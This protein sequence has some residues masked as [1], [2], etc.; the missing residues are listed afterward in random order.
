MG[1]VG[2]G[3]AAPGARGPPCLSCGAGLRPGPRTSSCWSCSSWSSCSGPSWSR[4]PWPCSPWRWSPWPCWPLPCWPWPCSPWPSCWPSTSR[5]RWSP[6]SARPKPRRP[7]R[8][9]CCG[10]LRERGAGL[11][12][13][14]LLALRLGGLAGRDAGLGGLGLRRSCSSGAA[15]WAAACGLTTERGV[16]AAHQAALAAGRG[17]GVDGADLG[18]TIQGRGS[19]GDGHAR[20]LG[21]A[22]GGR[23]EGILDLRLGGRAARLQDGVAA[24]GLSDALEGL[25]R[26]CAGPASG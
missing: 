9:P 1:R 21:I 3:A 12:G 25:R 10:G 22:G 13:G 16:H 17:V 5:R 7:R 14:R 24:V 2:R 18:R 4:S 15:T 11:A 26:P 23:S 8:L 6:W 20:R 19:L